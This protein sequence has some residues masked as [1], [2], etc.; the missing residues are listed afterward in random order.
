MQYL[1]YL[2]FIA[3]AFVLLIG[4]FYYLQNRT[5]LRRWQ[6]AVGEIFGWKPVYA[7]R[8]GAR[9]VAEVR[10]STSNG[11]AITFVSKL[12]RN[13]PPVLA[14][15]VSVLYDPT[16]PT[17]AELKEDLTFQHAPVVCG[18]CAVVFCIGGLPLLLR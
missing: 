18:I 1:K 7:S 10:F 14:S 4:A 2:P 16:D 17:R 3:A 5:R 6:P 15:T 11:R 12:G 9:Y 8:G 13:T